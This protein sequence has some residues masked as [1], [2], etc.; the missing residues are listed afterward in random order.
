VALVLT[1]LYGFAVLSVKSDSLPLLQNRMVKLIE[2]FEK[3][4]K[5]KKRKKKGTLI[6]SFIFGIV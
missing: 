5:E 3:K 6:K 2:S 1:D 4:R